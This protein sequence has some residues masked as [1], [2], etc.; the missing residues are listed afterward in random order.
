ML[1]MVMI[2]I[3]ATVFYFFY[4]IE[5]NHTDE[6]LKVKN[7]DSLQRGFVITAERVR[8]ESILLKHIEAV[9]IMRSVVFAKK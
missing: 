1:Y 2:N 3:C 5:T 4:F 7:P 9:K 8:F 6:E